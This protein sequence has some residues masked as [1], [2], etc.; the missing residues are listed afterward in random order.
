MGTFFF[1]AA[2]VLSFFQ[3]VRKPPQLEI[4]AGDKTTAGVSVTVQNARPYT[5]FQDRPIE[6]FEKVEL[7]SHTF[8][9][10]VLSKASLLDVPTFAKRA[11]S[12]TTLEHQGAITS[13]TDVKDVLVRSTDDRPL[14]LQADGD[15]LGDELVAHFE[16]APKSLTVVS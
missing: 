2:T 11:L 13:L 15:Y 10:A 7:D 12:K 8:S 3:Y 5:Y 4:T 14:P 1:S 16:I 6:L 9:A